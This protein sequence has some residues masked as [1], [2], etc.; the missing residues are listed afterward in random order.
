MIKSHEIRTDITA[1]DLRSIFEKNQLGFLMKGEKLVESV[2]WN[3][4]LFQKLGL[5]PEFLKSVIGAFKEV[6]LFLRKT[7]NTDPEL[8]NFIQ[9]LEQILLSFEEF[10]D[11]EAAGFINQYFI[12][13]EKAD[14][15]FATLEN[16]CFLIF[17]KKHLGR[18]ENNRI[19]GLISLVLKN[20]ENWK[21]KQFAW[22]YTRDELLQCRT[23]TLNGQGRANRYGMHLGEDVLKI[24]LEKQAALDAVVFSMLPLLTI[25][26]KRLRQDIHGWVQSGLKIVLSDELPEF[27][28]PWAYYFKEGSP[29]RKVN[30]AIYTLLQGFYEL[31]ADWEAYE[32]MSA[33]KVS[34][35]AE[36]EDMIQKKIRRCFRSRLGQKS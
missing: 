17:L 30:K 8:E 13:N 2:D 4:V 31:P 23:L 18:F 12:D 19:A 32:K 33:D 1:K 27:D 5:R 6:I 15:F 11:P 16:A 14:A 24:L 7:G 28:S 34:S 36:F 29:K 9:D 22:S 25:S 26:E 10:W 3:K 21:D 20:C 35:K